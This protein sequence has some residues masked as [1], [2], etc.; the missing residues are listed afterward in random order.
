[1]F[2]GVWNRSEMFRNLKFV[3]RFMPDYND[4]TNLSQL[5]C[6]VHFCRNLGGML[7]TIY[8]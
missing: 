8:V 3:H 6:I 4:Q 5:E 2:V 7:E 1:M